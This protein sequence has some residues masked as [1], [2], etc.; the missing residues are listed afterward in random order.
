MVYQAT[1]TDTLSQ[2]SKNYIGLTDTTFKERH[3]NH[4]KSFKN[5]KYKTET[6]LSVHLWK[7][8]E[9]KNT[10]LN[11]KLLTAVKVLTLSARYVNF[12]Q[13]KSIT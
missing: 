5:A 12:A 8:K 9:Q 10:Q 4:K 6:E 3:K 1:V 13:K 2:K 7:L 11:G